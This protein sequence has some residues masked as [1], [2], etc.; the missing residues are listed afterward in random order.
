M[1]VPAGFKAYTFNHVGTTQAELDECL[2][3]K[4]DEPMLLYRT[5]DA[6]SGFFPEVVKKDDA[7]LAGINSDKTIFKWTTAA[8]DVSDLLFANSGKDIWI[9]VHDEFVRTESGTIPAYKCYLVLDKNSVSVPV[10]PIVRRDITGI[11]SIDNGQLVTDNEAGVWYS[12][13]GYRLNGKPS[14]KGIYIHQGKKIVIK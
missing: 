8:T 5:G 6:T 7:N 2:Y 1:R 10:L 3:I 11:K 12:I 4:K 9:L 14:K 13:N